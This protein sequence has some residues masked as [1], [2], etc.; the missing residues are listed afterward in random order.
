MHR[1]MVYWRIWGASKKKK[2]SAD[3]IWRG[4]DTIC[5]CHQDY[6]QQAMKMHTEVM[7]LYKYLYTINIS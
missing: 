2:Q 7:L 5:V 4:F 6:G 1:K 3:V